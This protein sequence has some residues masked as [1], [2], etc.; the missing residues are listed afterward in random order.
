M[1]LLRDTIVDDE[2]HEYKNLGLFSS[3]VE[4]NIHRTCKKV[5]LIFASNFDHCKVNLLV[6]MKLWKQACLL[7]LVFGT[8]LGTELWM[9]T[10]TLLLMIERW[11]YW[12]LKHIFYV[13]ELAPGPLLLKLSG[14]NSNE[15]EVAT[16]KLLFSGRLITEHKMTPLIKDL[17]DIRTK[18]FFDSDI[19]SLGAL[20]SIAES[21]EKFDLF[22]YFETWYNNSIFPTYTN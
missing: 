16:K 20:P 19:S 5:G 1:W 6:Y 12:F 10:P 7:S 21:L 2:L 13:P 11:Q 22:Y 17:F 4:D 8:A 15:S 14:P 3:N 9:L 18:S